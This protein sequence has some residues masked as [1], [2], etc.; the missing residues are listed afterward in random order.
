VESLAFVAAMAVG[1]ILANQIQNRRAVR[2][3]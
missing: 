1:M 3:A 2:K